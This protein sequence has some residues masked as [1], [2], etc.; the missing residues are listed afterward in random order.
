M[1]L[2]LISL[3]KIGLLINLRGMIGGATKETTIIADMIE[4]TTETRRADTCTG[5][6]W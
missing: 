1:K 5:P 6:D 3:I 2:N 4:P